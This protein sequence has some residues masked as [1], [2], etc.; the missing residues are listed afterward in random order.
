MIEEEKTEKR[1]SK[2]GKPKNL[3]SK[4]GKNVISAYSWQNL[5]TSHLP[6]LK[7]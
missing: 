4:K 6:G 2:K 5:L 3:K 7:P 1:D